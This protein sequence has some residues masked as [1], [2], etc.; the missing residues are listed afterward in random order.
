MSKYYPQEKVS[1]GHRKEG[2]LERSEKFSASEIAEICGPIDFFLENTET[3]AYIL[4]V[5][6][7]R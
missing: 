2:Y 5:I 1:V 6:W 4:H 3:R 7:V